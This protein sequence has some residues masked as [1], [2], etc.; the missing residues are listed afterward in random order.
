MHT[1]FWIKAG[2]HLEEGAG[3]CA[4]FVADVGQA[5]ALDDVHVRRATTPG[6][7]T[8]TVLLAEHGWWHEQMNTHPNGWKG[9][10]FEAIVERF[11]L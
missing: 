5:A 3:L 2:D 4:K 8:Y 9:Y 1:W 10:P 7:E 11:G 6:G